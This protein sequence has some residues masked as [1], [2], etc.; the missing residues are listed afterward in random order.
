MDG[1]GVAMVRWL[2]W[3]LEVDGGRPLTARC[4]LF[5]AA[6]THVALAVS[7]HTHYP[8]LLSTPLSTHQ[9][10]CPPFV[11]LPSTFFLDQRCGASCPIAEQ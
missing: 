1:M 4:E 6:V 5:S 2:R 7:P 11:D 9:L 8:L 3:Q 10:T